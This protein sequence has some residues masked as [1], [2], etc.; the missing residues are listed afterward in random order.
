MPHAMIRAF[1]ILKK[2]AAETNVELGELVKNGALISKA[3]EEVISGSLN[4]HF[5]LQFGKPVRG[6]RLI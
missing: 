2:A 3:C 4:D 1:G 5:P 6:H